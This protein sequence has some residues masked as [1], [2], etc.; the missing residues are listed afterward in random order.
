LPHFGPLAAPNHQRVS[1]LRTEHG[2]G[3]TLASSEG[4]KETFMFMTAALL[5]GVVGIFYVRR[6]FARKRGGASA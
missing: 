3:T 6:R 5:I 2:F 4:L 1:T